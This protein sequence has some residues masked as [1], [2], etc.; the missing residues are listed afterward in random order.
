MNIKSECQIGQQLSEFIQSQAN[1]IGI[2]VSRA[3]EVN[4]KGTGKVLIVEITSAISAGNP[5]IGHRKS[6]AIA[7]QLYDNGE[8]VSSFTGMRLSMGGFF[9]GF[10]GSC[11][12]LGR[13]V[14]TLGQDVARWLKNPIDGA[15]LRN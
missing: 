4:K 6:T 11:S 2:N 8:E 7:G 9:G 13:T 3:D 10:K 14:K 15:H 12:V 5:F 1:G